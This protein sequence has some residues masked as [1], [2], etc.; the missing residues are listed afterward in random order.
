MNLTHPPSYIVF[1]AVA[2]PLTSHLLPTLWPSFAPGRCFR[3][4]V[5]N[6]LPILLSV[7]F[8][9]VFRPNE[10]HPT[11]RK[12]AGMILL[13]ALTPTVLFA[14]GYSSLYLSSAASLFTFL[15]LN[16]AKSSM[17]FGR[18]KRYP[19][20]W[21]SAEVEE[22]VSE[23]RKA[24]AA[25][26]RSDENRQAYI[27]ASRSTS[28]VIAK[29]KTEAWQTTCSSLSHKSKPK[30]VYF[31]LRSITGFSSSSSSSPNFPN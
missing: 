7:P 25:A 11:F 6:H 16:A 20:V 31:L 3:I 2:P 19:K 9:P 13:L 1:L 23:R 28:S 24:F 21:W 14:E 29:V 15:V 8:S 5:L 12:F 22:A 30:T 4:W 10:C 18:I 17:P 26:H 27:T